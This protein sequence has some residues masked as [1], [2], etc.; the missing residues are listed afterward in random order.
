MNLTSSG[1]TSQYLTINDEEMLA[2][3][4]NFDDFFLSNKKTTADY[5]AMLAQA[6]GTTG[7]IPRIVKIAFG[8]G[9][10][11]DD[12]G[13]PAPPSDNGP[14]NHEVLVKD[15]RAVTYPVPTTVC[16]EAAISI[17][18]ITEAINEAALIAEDGTTAARMRFLTSKGIDAETGLVIR[19]YVEF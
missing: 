15:V 16:F 17:G 10:E 2:L 12:Q 11:V 3:A 8:T 18:D 14:V 1:G 9:G 5:R 13:N 19:W 6:I 7:T 4:S